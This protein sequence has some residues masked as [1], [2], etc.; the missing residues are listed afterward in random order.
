M[1]STKYKSKT[2]MTVDTMACGS[3]SSM[4]RTSNRE[5]ENAYSK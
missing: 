1:D 2:L 3:L 4:K 5:G